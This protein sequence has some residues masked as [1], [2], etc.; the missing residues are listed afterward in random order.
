LQWGYT[1]GKTAS[2]TRYATVSFS[3]AHNDT[4]YVLLSFQNG[5]SG[6]DYNHFGSS[7]KTKSSV[8]IHYDGNATI[9]SGIYWTTIG[10]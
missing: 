5:S 9:P 10:L 7:N 2:Q 8:D 4:N 3:I 1:T 6:S